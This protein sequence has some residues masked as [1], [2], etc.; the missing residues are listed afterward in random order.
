MLYDG[1]VPKP[2]ILLR[3]LATFTALSLGSLTLLAHAQTLAHPGWA[4]NGVTV[5]P[6]WKRAVYYRI[7]PQRFQATGDATTGDLAGIVQRIGYIQSLGVDAIIIDTAALP[8]PDGFDDLTRAAAGSHIR[9]LAALG[10]PASQSPADDAQY[11]ALARMW[12][13]Q[14]AAGVYVPTAQLTKVDGA[15]HIANLLH[16]LRTLTNSSPGERV[17]LAEAAP[18]SDTGGQDQDLVAALARETQ[19]TTSLPLHADKPDAPSLRTQLQHAEALP[20]PLLH[21][22]RLQDATL[23]RTVAAMLLASRAAVLLDAGQELG[24]IA[25]TAPLMQWTPRNITTSPAPPPATVASTPADTAPSFSSFHEFVPPPDTAGFPPLRM[26][27][28]IVTDNPRTLHT[29]PN[30]LPG[31]TNGELD[32]SLSASNGATNNVAA[33]SEDA[34]SLLNFYRHLIQLH[35]DNASLRNGQQTL[36]DHD[37]DD[38]LVWVRSAPAGTLTVANVV[39]VCNLSARPFTLD[40]KQLHL[41]SGTSRMLLGTTPEHLDNALAIAPFAVYIGEVR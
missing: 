26:P 23:G 29:D 17:L 35:H 5:D 18:A 2:R 3:C 37:A 13:N 8:S 21:A 1:C 6:W 20:N 40:F 12:L 11:L 7:D 24:L 19:L 15:G 27:E 22:A 28:I 10:A 14:G 34:T 30:T 4:G 33:E 9:V 38:A 25:D 36:L 31:F 32:A 16:A 41:R 39:V